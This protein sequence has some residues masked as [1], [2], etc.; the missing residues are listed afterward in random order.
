MSGPLQVHQ[1]QNPEKY[2]ARY[3]HSGTT[4]TAL[5]KAIVLR[6]TTGNLTHTFQAL[7]ALGLS[8]GEIVS[9]ASDALGFTG[10]VRIVSV[11]D[12]GGEKA[13]KYRV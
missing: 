8:P 2:E 4:A 5:L 1:G 7:P 13:A 6:S 11:T 3:L 12:Y 10:Y 9:L